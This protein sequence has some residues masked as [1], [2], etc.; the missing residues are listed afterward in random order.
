MRGRMLNRFVSLFVLALFFVFSSPFPARGQEN[1]GVNFEMIT[2]LFEPSFGSYSVWDTLIAEGAR[3]EAFKSVADM[4]GGATIAAGEMVPLKGVSPVVMLTGY[5]KRGRSQWERYHNVSSI[6]EVVKILKIGAGQIVLMANRHHKDEGK[7][8]WIGF[9]DDQGSF[10]DQKVVRQKGKDLI[11]KDIILSVDGKRMLV[12]VSVEERTGTKDKPTYTY[13]PQVHVLDLKGK[14]IVKRAYVTGASAEIT[15]IST[16]LFGDEKKEAII[17]TGYVDYEGGKKSGWVMRLGGDAM[18]VWQQPFSRGVQ[19]RISRS[20]S[21]GSDHI[22]TLGDALPSDGGSAGAWLMKLD[23]SS[24]GVVWQRFYNGGYD[25]YGVDLAVHEDGLIALMMQAKVP[26]QKEP[27]KPK[28][29]LME[30]DGTI[31]GKMDYVQMLVLD[32]R[33]ITLDG[34]GYFKGLGAYGHQM[35]LSADRRYLIAGSVENPFKEIYQMYSGIV[36]EGAIPPDQAVLSKAGLPGAE[37]TVGALPTAAE[38][39]AEGAAKLPDGDVPEKSLSGLALLNKKLSEAA[40][41][42]DEVKEEKIAAPKTTLDGWVFAGNGPEA[43]KDPCI[44]VEASLP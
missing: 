38:N 1:C 3:S 25:Y 4:G 13:V 35:V 39:E 26:G 7:T 18:M 16:G 9:F 8:V 28:V 23:S 43:Y 17:A 42:K 31:I 19:A 22:L 34:E 14:E 27:N 44:K 24:G 5:D 41:R 2:A 15:G 32:P 10:K 6:T 29:P 37:V 40:S 36:P 12:A 21:Y 20:V 11:G 33:G 30:D